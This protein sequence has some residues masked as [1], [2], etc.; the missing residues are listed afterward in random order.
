MPVI[1]EDA[2]AQKAQLEKADSDCQLLYQVPLP[3][4]DMSLS[5]G[6]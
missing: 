2:A 1:N 6:E 5:L 3:G 4:V